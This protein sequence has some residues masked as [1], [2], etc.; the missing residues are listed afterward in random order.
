MRAADAGG[1]FRA[2]PDCGSWS[3]AT[4]RSVS[5]VLSLSRDEA[6]SLAAVALDGNESCVLGRPGDCLSSAIPIPGV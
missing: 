2:L 6:A 4:S 3:G 1:D 5:L